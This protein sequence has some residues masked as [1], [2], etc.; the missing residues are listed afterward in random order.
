MLSVATPV[1]EGEH[2][3]LVC[4][5]ARAGEEKETQTQVFWELNSTS[6][7]K[8][9]RWLIEIVDKVKCASVNAHIVRLCI[10]SQGRV[11]QQ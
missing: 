4:V 3:N 7:C 9:R 11:Q 5:Y 1:L 2:P 8:T 10:F 6:R